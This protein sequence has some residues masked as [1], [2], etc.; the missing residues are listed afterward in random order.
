MI[1]AKSRIYEP[2]IITKNFSDSLFFLDF[3]HLSS[4]F[5]MEFITE[6][7]NVKL[8]KYFLKKDG[9]TKNHIENGLYGSIKSENLIGIDYFISLGANSWGMARA[10]ATTTKNP[11]IITYFFCIDAECV[12][13]LS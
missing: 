10:V 5:T 11:G 12:W 4:E 2:K 9:I 3:F 7:D 6:E 1:L 8:I 13:W